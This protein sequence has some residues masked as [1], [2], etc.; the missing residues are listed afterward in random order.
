MSFVTS[1]AT[2]LELAIQKVRDTQRAYDLAEET[3]Q[4]LRVETGEASLRRDGAGEELANARND[5]FEAAVKPTLYDPTPI[6]VVP[7][8]PSPQ[9]TE[10][11][12]AAWSDKGT[13]S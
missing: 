6:R 2:P 13:D 12:D 4:R 3:Y 5:L 11:V 8:Y 10:G 1:T 7:S 9:L